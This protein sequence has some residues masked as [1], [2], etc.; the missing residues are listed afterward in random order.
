MRYQ[1]TVDMW[2]HEQDIRSGKMVLQP[3]QWVQCGK[4]PKSRFVG[5]VGL[6]VRC[7]HGAT[8]QEAS[9]RYLSLAQINK[10]M[11]DRLRA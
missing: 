4:G 2:K 10:G 1:K 9:A 3:G 5:V 8:S 6:S 7:T 11:N